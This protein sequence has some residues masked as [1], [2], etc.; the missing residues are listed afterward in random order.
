MNGLDAS[1]SIQDKLPM[2]TLEATSQEILLEDIDSGS[3]SDSDF[4]SDAESI[5]S[6]E[7]ISS[8]FSGAVPIA[9]ALEELRLRLLDLTGRNR[10][11][12]F[13]HTPGK[14]LQFVDS[15]LGSVFKRLM[16]DSATKV[17]IAPL[18]EPDAHQWVHINGRR[19]RP[20]PR[21]FATGLGIDTD[22][23][24]RK[25]AARSRAS[26]TQVQTLFYAEDLGK[27]CRK[28]DREAKLALQETGANM[29]YLVLGFLEFP[30]N[31]NSE[32]KYIAPLIAVPVEMTRAD[33]GQYST[34]SL[35]YTGEEL[36]ENLSLR[37]KLKR[38]FG[39]NLPAFD[40]ET[41][42]DL[43]LA[44]EAYFENLS[45]TFAKQP[46]WRVRRMMTLTLMSF[47]NMLLVRDLDP[48][49][50]PKDGRKS[51]LLT[52][53]VVKQ[54]FE[55]KPKEG[56][57]QYAEE[58]SIDEHPE[59]NLPLV[60]DADS[61]Q[62][63]ALID[64]LAGKSLVIEGPPGTGKSQTITNLI[65]ASLQAG[66]KV[67]FVAEKMA[68]L[69]VVKS[70]LARAHLDPFILEL[71]SN[72]T[73][74]KQVLEELGRRMNLKVPR[75]ADLPDLLVAQEEKRQELKAYAELMNT[76][77]GNVLELT[78]H[79]VMWRAERHRLRCLEFESRI[80]SIICSPAP[81]TTGPELSATR[82]LL[83]Y[84]AEQHAAVEVY[85]S[86]HPFWGFYPD[87]FKPED[88]L[89]VQTTLR[90][91]A[92]RFEAFAAAAANAAHLL[93]GT[94]LNVSAHGAEN[95]LSILEDL[96]PA[97]PHEVD[98]ALLPALFSPE[99][100]AGQSSLKVLQDVRE[101]QG[102]LAKAEAEL[103]RVLEFTAPA[104][105]SV[106]V[107]AR[108]AIETLKSLGLGESDQAHLYQLRAALQSALQPAISALSQLEDIAKLAGLPFSQTVKEA[109]QI[110][111]LLACAHAAPL[112]SLHMRHEGMRPPGAAAVLRDAQRTLDAI[113]MRQTEFESRLYMDL[114]PDDAEL[115]TAILTLRAGA[116]WYRPFQGTWRKAVGTHRRLERTKTKSR[117]ADRLADLEAI[118]THLKT[119]RDWLANSALQSAAG[120]AFNGETTPLDDLATCADWV[121]T[122]LLAFE[123]A[124]IPASQFDP[125][126][127][128]R[129]SVLRLA[130]QHDRAQSSIEA[131]Q[132]LSNLT[133][134][135]LPA[136]DATVSE[137]LVDSN[138]LRR[139]D[140]IQDIL[141]SLERAELLMSGR[142]RHGCSV[143][144]GVAAIELSRRMP[145]LASELDAHPGGRAL[146]GERF[147]GRN[148]QLDTAF[149]AHTYGTLVKKASLPRAIEQVLVSDQCVENHQRLSQYTDVI[150][151]GW[152]A[153]LDFGGAM[154]THGKFEPA[155]WADPSKRSTS[156]YAQDL[157]RRTRA[158]YDQMPRLLPWSQYVQARRKATELHLD[159]FV[160]NLEAGIIPGDKLEHA[161][162]YRFYASIA[163]GIFDKSKPLR[164][165]SGTRHSS[166]RTDFAKLD[167]EIIELRGLQVAAACVKH[168][169]PPRGVGGARVNDK[170][171][172]VL[173][174][175]LNGQT[176]PRVT[177]RQMLE[178][179]GR[180][181]Q[182]LKPC[183]M[184]GPQAVAQFLKPGHLKFDIV[185]M[186]E[187]SQLRPEQA[188]GA[189]AR[190]AQLVVVGD[191]KQLPPT[192]F[193]SKAA[194]ADGG[195]DGQGPLV[196]SEAESILDVCKSHFRPN[197]MLR[198]HYRSRHESLISFSNQH[199]YG[200]NLVV[201]PSPFA[202][203][204]RLGLSYQYV[205]DGEYEGQMNQPE[206]QRLVDAVIDHIL[207]RPDDSLGIVTTNIKQRD[208]VAEMLEERLRN[209][210]EAV[211]FKERWAPQGMDMF[212]K[213]LE[214]VQGDERDCIMI[215]TT[216]G[217]PKGINVVRQNFGPISRSGGWRRLN[218]LFTR[219]RKSV[220]VFSSMRPEDIVVDVKTPEGTQALRN[221]LQFARDGVLAAQYET[222]LPPDSD[223]EVAVM[224]VLR[225]KGYEVVPQLGVAGFRIDIAVKHPLHPGGYLA[226]IECDGATYHSGRSVRDRDRIRQ[227]ILEG[228][229]WKDRIW[230]IWSTDW[231]RNPL[232]ETNRLVE[233]L[234]A[235]NAI[236]LPD[237]HAT[238]LVPEAVPAPEVAS[239]STPF[240][241]ANLAQELLFD[242]DE[243]E[244]EV[245][246]DD[247][248]S[249]SPSDKPD[250][251]LHVRITARKTDPA[252]GLVAENTPL[253]TV[254]IGATIGET[255]VLR[256]PGVSPQSFLVHSIGRD[257]L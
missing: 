197:R 94:N 105:E 111:T 162:E 230:R 247:L 78:V 177:V 87:E 186:D 115:R 129:A 100:P 250:E 73:S 128:D 130:A 117:S 43:A 257:V 239:P 121:R 6:S 179:A 210:P 40:T 238:Q 125:L 119:R 39:V 156:E 236:P 254:L 64:V 157:A 234:E 200:G 223:F 229:G 53:P 246:I 34:F 122:T 203:S 140:A 50:W 166:V 233:F 205:S 21:A 118:N 148:T 214:N 95:L 54:V 178:R 89:L 240:P 216:F 113:G 175:Y 97:D 131:L 146:L 1:A 173:L 152:Q 242:E 150:N 42:G 99:D 171:E 3:D 44:V 58:H 244:L 36:E 109:S 249:Y 46:E 120:T 217:K 22:Y 74:K 134:G 23:E 70:R 112:Q 160:S 241:E 154:A 63:S 132:T 161:Y 67:L 51:A 176:R 144:E 204:K 174:D 192:S 251:V 72:K 207:H 256:V 5:E 88:N 151:Q 4:D 79:Q 149:A 209:M 147:E 182:E 208:L 252:A 221:Y 191:S 71:H 24:L 153:A 232:A 172:M 76:R 18:P 219:A 56:D 183:F 184:M 110:E 61:S 57:R 47:T 123:A 137:R 75:H 114:V 155:L 92:E 93:G 49:N 106:A 116:T 81:R 224:D 248:V 199:F 188:I 52:H 11:I 206:A 104:D 235:R 237:E 37:E 31:P 30:E 142:I 220:V 77:I 158:A 69:E 17:R 136:A 2:D 48:E 127:V 27:H 28:L 227:E 101:R 84:L 222:G 185:V 228:L 198:W 32:K 145:E 201:F 170:T 212:I 143:D 124:E 108:A 90:Q 45:V 253:G 16:D 196:T 225:A 25:Q 102:A 29:L 165:F 19:V 14:S 8:L 12:N 181:M 194:A 9:V 231:F 83:R 218:V 138:W 159:D 169:A 190:G 62:H 98:F 133:K 33:Q 139:I 164:T 163:Q 7:T 10:L 60:Y 187:A 141:A 255:V 59:A 245:Q 55:G 167:H 226:A 243:E 189:L 195:D 96:A 91:F 168:S 65:A 38:D 85:G 215:S 213:N 80:Q 193:F 13:K 126:Q 107:A 20:E 68:A 26:S 15:S 135:L 202:K 41:D 82:D 35:N 180:A 86:A 211:A 66:K 103:H